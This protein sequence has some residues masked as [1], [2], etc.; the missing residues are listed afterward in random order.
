MPNNIKD[1]SFSIEARQR[2]LVKVASLYY[3]ENRTQQ[4]IA[5]ILDVSRSG[6]SRLLTEARERGVV[7]IIIHHPLRTA[8]HLEAELLSKFNLRDVRILAGEYTKRDEVLQKLG[9]LAAVYLSDILQDGVRIGIS[10]GTALQYMIDAL[11]PLNFP[12]TEVVQL[13]GATGS[14]NLPNHGPILAQLLA[15]KLQGRSYQIHAPLIVDN[16]RTKEVLLNEKNIKTGLEKAKQADIALLGIGSTR[17]D[18]NSLLRTGYLSI[19]ETKK[20]RNLGA[21]GDVCAQHYNLNGDWLDIDINQR[22]I[23]IGLESLKKIDTRIGVA[24]SSIKA[25]TIYGAL[26]GGYVNVLISDE[27]A[28]KRILSIYDSNNTK[29]N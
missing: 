25:Q 28:A 24:G 22:V 17:A 14:E 2:T 6:V 8:S 18:L 21:V 15:K 3:E 26:K 10:W 7:E 1:E 13:I 20:I 4:E 16:I 19:E 27:Q 11:K 23:G 5:K 12:K 29:I 9:G